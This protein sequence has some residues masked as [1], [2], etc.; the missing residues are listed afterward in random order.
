MDPSF[1][2]SYW[3]LMACFLV[4]TNVKTVIELRQ[5]RGRGKQQPWRSAHGAKS[6]EHRTTPG[7]L[8]SRGRLVAERRVVRDNGILAPSDRSVKALPS[9]ARREPDADTISH[10][11]LRSEARAF[12]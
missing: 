8:T 4:M 9:L 10:V 11:A 12:F 6:G 3:F 2:A 1:L 5:P 7:Y